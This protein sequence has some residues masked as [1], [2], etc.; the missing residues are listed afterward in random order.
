MLRM[1]L[2]T[3]TRVRTEM[4]AEQRNVWLDD[5]EAFFEVAYDARRPFVVHSGSNRITVLGTK[6]SVYKSGNSL[7]VAVVEGHVELAAGDAARQVLAKA[8]A[9]AVS[10][11]LVRVRHA[12]KGEI[13]ANLSWLSGQLQFNGVALGTAAEQFNRY[14]QKKLVIA[15]PAAAAI[16][17]GGT[18][19]AVNVEQF[20]RLLSSGFGLV[21]KVEGDTIRVSSPERAG[22]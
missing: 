16:V 11:G 1:T 3:F 21:V 19:E 20:S 2:N 8:D 5:G 15:D 6:F 12:A 22:G 4:R 10:P 7:Q 14:N 17:I 13:D 18:F 9:A